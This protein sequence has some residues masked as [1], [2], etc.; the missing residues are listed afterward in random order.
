MDCTSRIISNGRAGNKSATV[1]FASTSG[2]V[3]VTESN[4]CGTSSAYCLAVTVTTCYVPGTITFSY[5][6]LYRS[7]DCALGVTSLTVAC[8]GAQGGSGGNATLYNPCGLGGEIQSTLTVVPASTLNVYVGG[9][10]GNEN[11]YRWRNSRLEWR[12]NRRK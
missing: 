3:C 8:Y 5:T 10:G 4:I 11:S 1:T 2:S 7:L 9:A 6:E 12:R